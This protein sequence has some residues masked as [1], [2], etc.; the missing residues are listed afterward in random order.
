MNIRALLTLALLLGVGYFVATTRIN[1]VPIDAPFMSW[2]PFGYWFLVVLVV[3]LAV[4]VVREDNP[5]NWN[6]AVDLALLAVLFFGPELMENS[7]RVRDSF[8]FLYVVNYVINPSNY[9]QISYPLVNYLQNWPG[10]FYTIGSLYLVT[11]FTYYVGAKVTF[12]IIQLVM[13]LLSFALGRTIFGNKRGSILMGLIVTAINWD[14][15]VTISPVMFGEVLLLAFVIVM[16]RG[17]QK[18]PEVIMLTII[19]L[20]ATI[21]HG[22]TSLIFISIVVVTPLVSQLVGTLVARFDSRLGGKATSLFEF[23]RLVPSIPI[24]LVCVL[25]FAIWFLLEPSAINRGNL[26]EAFDFALH[27]GV[28]PLTYQLS[29]LTPGRYYSVITAAIYLVILACWAAILVLLTVRAKERIV[30]YPIVLLLVAIVTTYLFAPVSQ[31]FYDRLFQN[32]FPFIAIFLVS[33]IMKLRNKWKAVTMVFLAALLFSGFVAAF[34][35]EAVLIY[36]QTEVAGDAFVSNLVPTDTL[37]AYP[38]AGPTLQSL[39]DARQ[40]PVVLYL[41]P[42]GNETLFHQELVLS[43]AVV[44]SLVVANSLDYYY[45]NSHLSNYE[46]VTFFNR[47]YDSGSFK[48][49]VK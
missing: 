8:S 9:H 2:I 7:V 21:T 14:V 46:N 25:A 23:Q 28:T 41:L 26:L 6:F 3:I 19:I 22:L 20:A 30:A 1:Y 33:S 39:A 27:A 47:V 44:D 42:A 38:S 15:W 5:K 17:F 31:D 32:G 16:C 18:K 29:Y 13:L 48:L 11:G 12:V 10:F 49:Y 35:H 40:G 37:V 45:G 43:T 4:T 36:P 34:S 24:S